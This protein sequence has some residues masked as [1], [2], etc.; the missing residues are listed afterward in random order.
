MGNALVVM[1]LH[2]VHS[3]VLAHRL[4]RWAVLVRLMSAADL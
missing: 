1:H 3:H 4:W 2:R